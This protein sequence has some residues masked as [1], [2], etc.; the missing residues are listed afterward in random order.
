MIKNVIK[1]LIRAI[2]L[3]SL[4]KIKQRY[5]FDIHCVFFNFV[6]TF[7]Y[8]YYYVENIDIYVMTVYSFID[9]ETYI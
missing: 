2:F 1:F 8:I 5:S 9:P 3:F 7:K 4:S 6:R